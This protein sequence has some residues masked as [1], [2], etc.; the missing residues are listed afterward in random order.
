MKIPGGLPEFDWNIHVVELWRSPALPDTV[1]TVAMGALVALTCGWLGCFLILQGQAFLGDAISHTVLLGI[2]LAALVT[3]TTGG[4]TL[5]LAALITSLLTAGLIQLLGRS[6]RVKP[7]AATG[8]VFTTLFALGVFLLGTLA[9]KAHLDAQHTLYGLLEFVSVGPTARLLGLTAPIALWQMLIV[10]AGLLTGLVLVYPR[11]LLASFDPALSAALGQRPSWLRA[12]L[13]AALSLT[14]VASFSSVGAVLVV[15]LLVI[16][17]ATAFLLCQ[18]LSHMLVVTSILGV[19]V[20]VIGYHI[21]A[22]LETTAAATMVCVAAFQFAIVFLLAPREGV[23]ARW[24]RIAFRRIQAAHEN[25]VRLLLRLGAQPDGTGQMPLRL[26]QA[27]GQSVGLVRLL[28]VSLWIRGWVSRSQGRLALTSR[29]LAE[30]HRLDRAHRLW[31]AYLVSQVGVALDHVHPTAEQLEHLLDDLLI[32]RID[33]ALGHPGID[34]HG[35]PIPRLPISAN[36][37][38][39][40]ALSRLRVGESGRLVGIA[41]PVDPVR[42]GDQPVTGETDL[43][44][45]GTLHVLARDGVEETWTIAFNSGRQVVCSHTLADQL[46]VDLGPS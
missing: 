17:P 23:L 33:D 25:L 37:P 38:S 16:P 19:V 11:L 34:P 27:S 12:S 26:A 45:G 35:A 18:R 43:P 32:A 22:W 4:A 39:V 41:P 6:S 21:A 15:G 31:E 3:G 36:R 30:A 7:D 46:L 42:P 10:C 13:L 1:I 9:G 24:F 40:F 20:A 14:V 2:V 8:I 5:L 29:G 28:A 44:L